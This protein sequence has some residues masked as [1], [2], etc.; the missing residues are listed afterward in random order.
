M[1]DYAAPLDDIKFTLRQVAGLEGVTSMPGFEEVSEDIVDAVLEEAGKF[2]AG[3]LGPLNR[4]GD[5]QGSRLEDGIVRTP[6]GF[7]EAYQQ[8][9][10]GGWNGMMFASD[11]GGMGFPWTLS[12]AITEMF[13]AANTGWSLCPMLT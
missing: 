5:E 12:M 2:A 11:W 4:I 13:D 10:E 7:R 9:V 6:E 8:Y 1:S 3:V